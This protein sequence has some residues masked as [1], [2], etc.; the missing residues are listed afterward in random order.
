MQYP[1]CTRKGC[2]YVHKIMTDQEKEDQKYNNKRPA[3]KESNNQIIKKPNYDKKFKGK[4][5][6][7]NNNSQGTNGMHSSMPLTREHQVKLGAGQGKPTPSNPHGYSKKQ[8]HILNF[9]IEFPPQLLKLPFSMIFLIGLPDSCSMR[10]F[11][12][13]LLYP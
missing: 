7:R 12:C 10:N 9:L 1:Q 4:K 5:D 11:I 8:L 13:F 3:G 2:P 6:T